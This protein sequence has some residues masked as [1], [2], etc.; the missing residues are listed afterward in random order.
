MVSCAGL[1]LRRQR[2]WS[3]RTV[4]QSVPRL[5]KGGGGGQSRFEGLKEKLNDGSLQGCGLRE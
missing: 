2:P 4:Y 5:E 3:N 1:C